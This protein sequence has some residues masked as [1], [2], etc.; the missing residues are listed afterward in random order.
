M[1]ATTRSLLQTILTDEGGYFSIEQGRA[2]LA[3]EATRRLPV[4]IRYYWGRQTLSLADALTQVAT[5]IALA[6]R[7]GEC[8]LRDWFLSAAECDRLAPL[9][10]CEHSDRYGYT[11]AAV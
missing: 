7:G 11:L 9:V 2:L 3:D 10:G 8:E 4:V 6:E 1:N 5:D